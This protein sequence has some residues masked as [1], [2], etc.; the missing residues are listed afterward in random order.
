MFL[1]SEFIDSDRNIPI[2]YELC[3]HSLALQ[4]I[5]SYQFHTTVFDN[6]NMMYLEIHMIC[7]SG[8]L[9]KLWSQNTHSVNLITKLW[10]SHTIQL[11][12][13][14]FRV[15]YFTKKKNSSQNTCYCL[16]AGLPRSTAVHFRC[17]LM[18]PLHLIYH[19]F[20]FYI[21]LD[22]TW[23]NAFRMFACWFHICNYVSWLTI[24]YVTYRIDV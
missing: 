15:T 8:M 4:R 13:R 1:E 14:C 23:L 10:R 7:S 6:I 20:C 22:V 2:T 12:F 18:T 21:C 5:Q 17:W 3:V 19:I 11:H 24:W 16:H 9:S